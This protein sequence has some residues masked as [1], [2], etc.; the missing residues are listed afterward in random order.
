MI[1]PEMYSQCLLDRQ[2]ALKIL[3]EKSKNM[4]TELSD[5]IEILKYTD[6]IAES[7]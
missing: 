5:C 6:H 2:N 7:T 4:E 1:D 3:D